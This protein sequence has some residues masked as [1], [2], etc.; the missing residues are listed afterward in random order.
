MILSVYGNRILDN[1]EFRTRLLKAF[2]PQQVMDYRVFLPGHENE[3]DASVVIECVSKSKW[4][5]NELSYKLLDDLEIDHAYFDK[6]EDLPTFFAYKAG[7]LLEGGDAL[8]VGNANR[9]IRLNLA[10]PRSIIKTGLE[11][12]AAA[13]KAK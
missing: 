1:G 10:M 7:V 2:E 9:F 13:I 11:R 12:M 8:F 6:D 5:K 4:G 3:T